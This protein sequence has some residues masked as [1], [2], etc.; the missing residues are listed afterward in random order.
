[1]ISKSGRSLAALCLVTCWAV[2]SPVVCAQ[3][4]NSGFQA[5]ETPID[6]ERQAHR[7]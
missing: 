5:M 7:A 6:E 1:M 2:A 4:S 3:S